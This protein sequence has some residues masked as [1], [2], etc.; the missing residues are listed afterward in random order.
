MNGGAIA[1]DLTHAILA[2]GIALVLVFSAIS[3]IATIEL[4]TAFA[5]NGGNSGEKGNSDHGK[6]SNHDAQQES[7]QTSNNSSNSSDSGAEDDSTSN[8][9]KSKGKESHHPS[10]PSWVEHLNQTA[11]EIHEKHLKMNAGFS[12]PY[13]ANLTYT[14]N[15]N[16]TADAIGN[17]SYTGDAQLS[18]DMSVWKSTPGQVK[19]DVTDGTLT[20]DGQSMEAHSGHAHYWINTNRMLIIAFMIE[21][22]YSEDNNKANDGNQTS[23]SNQTSTDNTVE[24]EDEDGLSEPQVRVLKL[25]IT[26]PEESAELPTAQS[27]DPIE[28]DVMSR[29]SKLA[30]MWFLEMD[31][32]VALST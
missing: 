24:S 18:L 15:A 25:W 31:G 32:E 20:V 23:T 2:A 3:T 14:L 4:P 12:G 19:M 11:D 29:Q 10:K 16:G 1:G 5:E 9:G 28:I 30:S 21:G 26:I 6:G 7:N 22:G 17:S 13:T 27:S 8:K